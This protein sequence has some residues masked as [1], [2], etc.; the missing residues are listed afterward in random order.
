MGANGPGYDAGAQVYGFS[1]EAPPSTTL[2]RYSSALLA[3]GYSA[4]G[5]D[6]AWTVFEGHGVTIE[7]QVGSSGP[8][9]DLVVR[10]VSRSNANGQP[11]SPPGQSNAGGTNNGNANGQPSSP[12]GQS[13]TP[14]PV[15]Q[16]PPPHA[17]PGAGS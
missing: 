9:T 2:S 1:S 17:T 10:V 6:G 5:S 7:V 8:P 11:S 13:K 3:A 14:L 16:P 12:P 15:P 4:R